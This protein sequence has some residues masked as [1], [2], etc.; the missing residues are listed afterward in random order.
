MKWIFTSVILFSFT[1]LGLY[2]IQGEELRFRTLDEL[3][4]FM[5][6]FLEVLE[7]TRSD[8]EEV[9]EQ[10][11]CR[12][13]LPAPFEEKSLLGPLEGE[14]KRLAE[15]FFAGLGTSSMMQQRT[16]CR[17]CIVEGERLL[18]KNRTYMGEKRRLTISL[19]VLGGLFV[20]ILFQ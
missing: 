12:C 16:H 4:A 20:A 8:L 17:A 13:H 18:A 6:V 15:R 5:R 11:R 1:G 7:S 19:S 2:R 10:T 14:E 9:L 3:C